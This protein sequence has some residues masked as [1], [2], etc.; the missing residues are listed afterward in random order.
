MP[1]LR[2]NQRCSVRGL[3]G[4]TAL[5]VEGVDW[6]RFLRLVQFHRVEGLAWNALALADLPA[7]VRETL[8]EA[9][10]AIAVKDLRARSEC[11]FLLESFEAEGLPLIL[12]KGVTLAALAYGNP[13]L[14]SAIDID[15]L[16][17]PA[18][19][20]KA[21]DLLRKCGYRLVAP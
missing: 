18:D 8:A 9:A 4:T 10:S 2:A 19:L 3:G 16:I 13:S 6:R 15:L 1:T 17:D 12:L 14:K 5:D 11:R 20:G 21:A 7:D